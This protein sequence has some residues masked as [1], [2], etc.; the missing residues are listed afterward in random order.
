MIS[1]SQGSTR[2]ICTVWY[3]A[4]LG[5]WLRFFPWQIQSKACHGNFF[6]HRKDHARGDILGKSVPKCPP[7][8][9]PKSEKIE[10]SVKKRVKKLTDIIFL[11]EWIKALSVSFHLTPVLTW[12][13]LRF[14][15]GMHLSKKSRYKT[16]HL[17][18][19]SILSIADLISSFKRQAS[20]LISYVNRPS[21]ATVFW[22]EGVVN[23][24]SPVLA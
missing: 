20:I 11:K 10:K 16:N 2:T 13:L 6:L 19:K 7:P 3:S 14:G 23:L 18:E 24:Y 22:Y 4:F 12:Y 15:N 8:N 1:L 17:L 21:S 9:P 5:G